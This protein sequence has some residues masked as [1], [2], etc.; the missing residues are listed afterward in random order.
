MSKIVLEIDI[1]KKSLS[2][3]LFK[4]NKF[5]SKT[6]DNSGAEFKKYSYAIR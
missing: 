5:Y 3:A 4:D 1:S 6:V 2:L